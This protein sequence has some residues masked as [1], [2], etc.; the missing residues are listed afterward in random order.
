MHWVSVNVPQRAGMIDDD[1]D[2]SDS[3]IHG[4]HPKIN[5]HRVR[6]QANLYYEIF[7]QKPTNNLSYLRDAEIQD[8][9]TYQ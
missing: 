4:G 8:G 6:P 2:L 3:E 1:F 9:D 5:T 7:V